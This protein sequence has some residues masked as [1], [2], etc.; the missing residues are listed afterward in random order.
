[1]LK[2]SRSFLGRIIKEGTQGRLGT[3]Y[4]GYDTVS[5]RLSDKG[6]SANY[7]QS[8]HNDILDLGQGTIFSPS[9]L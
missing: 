2:R 8:H 4:I 6:L 3:T 5:I 9:P 1:M 7:L